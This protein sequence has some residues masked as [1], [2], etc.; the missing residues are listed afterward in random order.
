MVRFSLAQLCPWW[1]DGSSGY[2]YLEDCYQT[3]KKHL[4]VEHVPCG[5]IVALV[6]LD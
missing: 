3:G 2:E 1:E 5:N 6:H 4:T